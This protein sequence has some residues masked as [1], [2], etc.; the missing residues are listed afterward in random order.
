[1]QTSI[2][3]E[4]KTKLISGLPLFLVN[5][6]G[7][8]IENRLDAI[9]EDGKPGQKAVDIFFGTSDKILLVISDENPENG[10]QVT[11]VV[12]E[13]IRDEMRPFLIELV[14]P[15]IDSIKDED[16]RKIAE[17]I[18]GIFN[19]VVGLYTDD[20]LEN[21]K[22]LQDYFTLLRKSPQTEQVVLYNLFL[23]RIK[24]AWEND[25]SKTDYYKFLESVLVEMWKLVKNGGDAGQLAETLRVIE[26]NILALKSA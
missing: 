23:N 4:G 21:G 2:A 16:N 18:K 17:F 24:E 8:L 12:F 5:Q 6:L 13:V 1:M 20:V 22:Q 15:S 10:K 9:L 11:T 19:D 26:G 3:K 7:D 14:Q 25:P